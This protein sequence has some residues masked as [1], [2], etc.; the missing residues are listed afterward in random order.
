MLHWT[1]YTG[2]CTKIISYLL[3]FGK[4]DQSL[5]MLLQWFSGVLWEK[6]YI[7]VSLILLRGEMAN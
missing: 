7:I 2:D 3:V 4:K 6:S 1:L 5:K